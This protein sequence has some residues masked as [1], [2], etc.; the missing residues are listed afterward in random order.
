MLTPDEIA[1]LRAA[2]TVIM[3]PHH[4]TNLNRAVWNELL[5]AWVAQHMSTHTVDAAL[6]PKGEPDATKD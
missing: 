1:R 6:G 4:E 5:D 3:T 2:D